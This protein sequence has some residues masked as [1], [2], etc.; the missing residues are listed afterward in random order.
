MAERPTGSRGFEYFQHLLFEAISP[1]LGRI[2]QNHRGDLEDLITKAV[3]GD[4]FGG[5]AINPRRDD[6]VRADLIAAVLD[7]AISLEHLDN[8]EI[9]LRR[10]PYTNTSVTPVAHA[11]YHFEH[12]LNETYILQNRLEKLAKWLE[13]AYRK[14]PRAAEA[15]ALGRALATAVKNILHPIISV[16]GRHVHGQPVEMLDHRRL[17]FLQMIAEAVPSLQPTYKQVI[18]DVRRAQLEWVRKNNEGVWALLDEYFS[19]LSDFLFDEAGDL[20]YP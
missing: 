15:R 5:S 3:N 1:E 16:R 6:F 2:F 11:R 14:T 7:I 20:Y 12:Y 4:Q 19:A 8:S 18:R 13:R 10:F 17:R 9:Y